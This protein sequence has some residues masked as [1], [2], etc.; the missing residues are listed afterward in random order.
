M[1]WLKVVGVPIAWCGQEVDP[2]LFPLFLLVVRVGQVPRCWVGPS[3][4]ASRSSIS[5]DPK[6]RPRLEDGLKCLS[7]CWKTW[8]C[9]PKIVVLVLDVFSWA[10]LD[11]EWLRHGVLAAGISSRGRVEYSGFPRI[12]E[13]APVPASPPPSSWW[14]KP[15]PPYCR[16]NLGNEGQKC[17]GMKA[18]LIHHILRNSYVGMSSPDAGLQD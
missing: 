15:M 12:A 4:Q 16:G 18:D 13:P 14:L 5:L 9:F 11:C 17:W 6:W 3:Q 1:F 2:H 7:R 8:F 10:L